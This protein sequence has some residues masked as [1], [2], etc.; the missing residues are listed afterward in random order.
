MIYLY[1]LDGTARKSLLKHFSFLLHSLEQVG[2]QITCFVLLEIRLP[3][4]GAQ[5]NHA[6]KSDVYRADVIEYRP[7]LASL[8]YG[9]VR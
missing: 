6:G 8:L 4:H 3:F 5:I 2:H 1:V 7:D 9:N